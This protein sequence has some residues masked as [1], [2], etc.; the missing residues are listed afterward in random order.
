M[1]RYL[2]V[3]LLSMAATVVLAGT[4][5]MMPLVVLSATAL[6]MGGTGHPLSTP[7]DSPE[8]ID[9]Y[10]NDA[11]NDYI[12]LTGFCDPGSCT[13]TAVSTPEQ[14]M[15]VSGTM[16]FDESVAQGVTNLD[17]AISA[18]PEGTE[19]VV[20][21]YLDLDQFSEVNESLGHSGGDRLLVM[22]ADRLC[23]AFGPDV[24]LGRFTQDRF[25]LV[26]TT[27]DPGTGSEA[28]AHAIE[29]MAQPFWINGQMLHNGVSI[30]LAEVSDAGV[31]RA[32]L[33]GASHA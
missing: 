8:F 28:A 26:M 13:P 15:P 22:A 5:T 14:F 11:N 7:Q 24:V 21:G 20:F 33:K 17:D 12:V 3:V 27:R 6:I 1:I 19:I 25:A 31:Q 29:C 10:V 2:A 32:Y 4:Q 9:S 18:Q 30:G 16:P 23:A